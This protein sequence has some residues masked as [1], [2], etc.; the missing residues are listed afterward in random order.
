MAARTLSQ[1]IAELNPTFN[2]QIKSVQQQQSL[3]PGEIQAQETAL[4][5]KKDVAYED[6][7][8]GARRRGLGFAGIPLG[9]QAKY[10]ATDY[11]PALAGLRQ[12]GQQ[13]AMSLQDAIFSIKERRD[14]L[15]QQIYQQEKD[16]AFQSRE[17]QLA[18]DAQLRAARESAASAGSGFS[19]TFTTPT[20]PANTAP[21]GMSG[22]WGNAAQR[23]NKGFNFTDAG[24]K[25]VSA[26]VYAKQNN[27]A[28]RSLL[29][30]M[31]KLGDTGAKKALGFVG[32]DFG[33]NPGKIGS[34]TQLYNNLVW[35]SGLSY[36]A[37]KSG[38]GG[39]GW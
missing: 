3:I 34:N 35:G 16:R 14:T 27:I 2:P 1:I 29:E 18:R 20:G 13:K 10:A 24:G 19:P 28:F 36:K 12:Q 23:A 22:G 9:E 39:G 32:N 5:A 33:Y 31:A 7:L 15:G 6:I 37:P 8:S 21:S 17:A 30:R 26:A 38:N 11:A 25:P 4:N